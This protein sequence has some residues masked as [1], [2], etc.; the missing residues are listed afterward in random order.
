[1]IDPT[2]ALPHGRRTAWLVGFVLLMAGVAVA[3]WL[4][5]PTNGPPAGESTTGDRPG[6]VGVGSAPSTTRS[7]GVSPR[8]P[9]V[10]GVPGGQPPPTILA[11]A[12]PSESSAPNGLVAW[13]T[14]PGILGGEY[15][16]TIANDGKTDVTGWTVVIQLTGVRPAVT[17][18]RGVMHEARGNKEHAFTPSAL[19]QT[20]PAG[21]TVRFTF[22]VQ[23]VLPSVQSCAID[24]RS[25]ISPRG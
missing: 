9:S 19:L 7:A 14:E 2:V 23:G 17:P 5:L 18:G 16:V 4:F 8:S 25:C 1:M 24:G 22:T 21:G 11:A 10:T 12:S 15:A 3:V 20:V 6:S 13:Y